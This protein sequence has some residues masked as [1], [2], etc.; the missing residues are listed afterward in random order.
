MSAR[1]FNP[2]NF[3]LRW[4]AWKNE[5]RDGKLTKVPYS[6]HTGHEAKA[7]D[8]RTWNT[9][10]AAEAR[11]RNIV[12]GKGGGIG[13]ELGDLGDGTSLVTGVAADALSG[14]SEMMLGI[15]AERVRPAEKGTT[16]GMVK[17]VERL[18]ERTLIHVALADGS[19]LVAEDAF[20]SPL[21][22]G[23]KVALAIEAAH[24]HLFDAH[25][26][27]HHPAEAG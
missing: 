11:A 24:A 13:I 23:D 20:V 3:N 12:N 25:G 18:G 22:P 26:I 14:A 1:A 2:F 21:R 5:P 17:V 15:R 19:S 8:P 27:G 4:V 16:T 9:R 7:D 10:S 6:P